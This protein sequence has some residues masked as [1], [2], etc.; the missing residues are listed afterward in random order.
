MSPRKRQ[1]TR[2]VQL[3]RHIEGSIHELCE[4][5][6]RNR[7]LMRRAKQ[8]SRKNRPIRGL[9]RDA[10]RAR[11]QNPRR[12][13]QQELLKRIIPSDVNRQ[14]IP[15]PASGSSRLLP[16]TRDRSRIPV[17]DHRIKIP[18]INPEFQRIRRR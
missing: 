17:Q 4:L 6:G 7:A 11:I 1:L 5:R 10:L 16:K 15:V 8:L 13:S 14:P 18:N 9:N 2:T 3:F 12:M